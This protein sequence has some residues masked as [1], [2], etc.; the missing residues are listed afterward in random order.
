MASSFRVACCWLAAS[1]NRGFGNRMRA[2][3]TIPILMLAMVGCSDTVRTE[4]KT[5]DDANHA[6]AFARGWLPPI[7]PDGSTDIVEENDLDINTGSG[8]FRFP[9]ESAAP[10]L[11]LLGRKHGALVTK[12]PYG[13]T[14]T[15]TNADTRWDISLD[16]QKGS[17]TYS[18]QNRK[19]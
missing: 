1:L 12:S 19:K 15:M 6:K 5:L 3:L 18:V 4:F 8:S 16:P 13:V 7:L 9:P 17:G 10:Y 11:E 14:I 2:T